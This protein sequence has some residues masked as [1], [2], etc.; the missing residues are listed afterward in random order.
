MLPEPTSELMFQA[1]KSEITA[2]SAVP[3]T[4]ITPRPLAYGAGNGIATRCGASVRL[5]IGEM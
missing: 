5:K 1:G 2:P 3:S 4:E